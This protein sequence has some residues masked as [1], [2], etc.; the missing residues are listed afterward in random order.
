MPQL[1]ACYGQIQ[2]P[3]FS[4]FDSLDTHDSNA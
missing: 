2:T 4:T 1:I 3:G